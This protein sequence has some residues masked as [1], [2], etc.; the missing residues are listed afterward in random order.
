MDKVKCIEYRGIRDLVAAEVLTDTKEEFTCGTPFSVAWSSELSR[1]TES[2]SES[3]YYDNI[4]S[5]VIDS[6]GADTVSIS[7]SAVPFDVYAK[8]TG[9]Y[10]DENIGMLVE[11]ECES[12]YY[13]IG[14]VTE[15]TSGE[16]VYVWRLKGKF[17]IPSETHATKNNGTDAN[18]QSLTYTGVNTTHVFAKRSKTERAINCLKSKCP[19]S[20][21]EFFTSVQTPDTVTEASAVQG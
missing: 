16:E 8:I 4:P 18:G 7:T 11:G 9:Q 21:E 10:Y 3:H 13:A 2:S 15:D 20:E 12:K 6:T 1:E 5:I 17:S 14:Y 19:L